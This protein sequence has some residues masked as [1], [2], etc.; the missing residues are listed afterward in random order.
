MSTT[1]FQSPE[2]RRAANNATDSGLKLIFRW[3]SWFLLGVI[4]LIKEMLRSVVGR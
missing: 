3:L 4:N 1:Y 2:F